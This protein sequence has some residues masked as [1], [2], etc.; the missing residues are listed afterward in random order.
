MAAAASRGRSKRSR[1]RAAALPMQMPLRALGSALR[2][3]KRPRPSSHGSISEQLSPR[4]RAHTRQHEQSS[5]TARTPGAQVGGV[6]GH[7]AGHG[8]GQCSVAA[9]WGAGE[10]R[11]KKKPL[12]R[13]D[14][15]GATRGS[16][17]GRPGRHS[18]QGHL[19][20][21]PL[22][23]PRSRRSRTAR[24]RHCLCKQRL[25][26]CTL[27]MLRLFPPAFTERDFLRCGLAPLASLQVWRSPTLPSATS[28][29]F[30]ARS[31]DA[32]KPVGCSAGRRGDRLGGEWNEPRG[33]HGN[34]PWVLLSLGRGPGA[35]ECLCVATGLSQS[36]GRGWVESPGQDPGLAGACG[37]K[38]P[39]SSWKL[40]C[41][42]PG[43][44]RGR[45]H[46]S[47]PPWRSPAGPQTWGSPEVWGHLWGL[48]R[49]PGI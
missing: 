24:Q 33:C 18:N 21:T 45:S 48:A 41:L 8:V 42:P 47:S 11:R 12:S 3:Q 10:T 17:R 29:G 27:C 5:S 28:A 46:H 14:R 26:P 43:L 49:G 20:G 31:R 38:T 6:W 32:H 40:L 23:C 19:R 37:K 13:D 44:R 15:G 7:C 30:I 25:I 9:T 22:T 36:S 16:S 34:W 2:S 35:C 1:G 4:W 39:V